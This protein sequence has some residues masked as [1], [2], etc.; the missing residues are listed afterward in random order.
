MLSSAGQGQCEAETGLLVDARYQTIID[1][2][3]EGLAHCQVIFD[4]DGSPVDWVFLAVNRAFRNLF[5]GA[6]PV[7]MRAST[8]LPT[9]AKGSPLPGGDGSS[10]SLLDDLRRLTASGEPQ[11]REYFV[12]RL[13]K[14]VRIS[15][16]SPSP[17]FLLA[18]VSDVT[19]RKQA[20]LAMMRKGLLLDA[21]SEYL[22]WVD[23]EGRILELTGAACRTLE[24]SRDELLGMTVYDLGPFTRQTTHRTKSGRELPVEMSV[25]TVVVDGVEYSCAACRD[26]SERTQM[27]ESLRVTQRSVDDSPDLIHWSDGEGNTVYANQALCNSLG[28]TVEEFKDLRVWDF[29][30]EV[31]PELYTSRFQAH[32]LQGTLQ[33]ETTLRGKQGN[34]I[35]V[36]GSVVYLQT[37]GR[38]VVINFF[39]DV[40]EQT[41]I[42]ES[43]RTTQ[44]T[45]DQSPEMVHWLDGTGRIVYANRAMADFCGY[46]QEEMQSLHL[47]DIT[48]EVTFEA[49]KEWWGT[50]AARAPASH[51]SVWRTRDGRLLPI[52]V[53]S[54]VVATPER[55]LFIN[56]GRDISDRKRAADALQESQRMLR[57]VLDTVPMHVAWKDTQLRF[58]GCNTLVAL[59][60]H[61]SSPDELIGL[62]QDDVPTLGLGES[63]RRDDLEVLATGLPKLQYEE[64]LTPPALPPRHVRGSKVPLRDREGRVFGVLGVHE[65]VTEH[66][67]MLQTLRERDEQ[68]RQSQK[69]EAIGRLAGGIAHD[70]NNVVTTI[71]GYSDLILAEPDAAPQAIAEDLGEIRAAAERA[72]TLTRQI[73]AFSRRQALEPKVL[74]LND[75][76]GETE[77]LLARTIGADID[78]R[79]ACAPDLGAVEIDEHEFVQVLLN[80]AVNARDAMPSGGTLTLSTAN[81]DLSQ[82]F[83][84]THPDTRPGPHVLVSMTDTG[85]GMDPETAERVFEPFFTT[86]PPGQGTGLGLSMV[87]GVVAQSGGCVYVESEP[88][89]GSSFHIYL[90]HYS[91]A[92]SAGEFAKGGRSS[93][94]TVLVVDDDAPFRKVTV[95]MLEKRGYRVLAAADGDQATDMLAG[96]QH[97]DLLLTEVVLP[98][99]L[100]GPH[101]A[102]R[103]SSLRP[104][105]PILY[106]S[107]H[108]RDS[109]E[110]AGRL[111]AGEDYLEKPFT[112]E[113]LVTRVGEMLHERSTQH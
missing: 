96:Q 22:L 64:I 89:K 52:G 36:H 55:T 16:S 88:G 84:E 21:T 1:A 4:G 110:I 29:D 27:E 77:R 105:L 28:Y 62:T 5:S 82:E 65:D 50:G 25:S 19:E 56:Y 53:T 76:I 2:L 78:L 93:V 87:Y 103:A 108:S 10:P 111:A 71:I 67:K 75:I 40:T 3:P 66:A 91:L 39:R 101:V 70:F 6:N 99:S 98:G 31:T 107:A 68:L 37:E 57:L 34:E 9:M 44:D 32:R 49:F 106:M 61:R 15:A 45:V 24:Y 113:H 102:Q 35:K 72:R 20:E 41:R 109:I 11:A 85:S 94:P 100:Q 42:A 58:L 86:K 54:Y 13:D 81:V 83:C 12:P 18:L 33:L 48:P 43:L 14:W 8:F 63:C 60:A 26:V 74:C 80:L 51:E 104:E 23:A 90:P 97:I 17:G 112:A 73:L 59:D 95:R 46:S 30:V 38:D 79:V 92:A 47:W 69:M 7:G